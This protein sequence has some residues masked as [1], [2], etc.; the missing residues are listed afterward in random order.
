MNKVILENGRAN[1]LSVGGV[2]TVGGDEGGAIFNDRGI[3]T[4]NNSTIRNNEASDDG[5]AIYNSDGEVTINNSTINANQS[6]GTTTDGGVVENNGSNAKLI[7]NSSTLSGNTGDLGGAIRNRNGGIVEINNSTLTQNTSISGG[8]GIFNDNSGGAVTIK[9][10][11]IAGNI[12]G[13]TPDLVGIVTGDANNLIG[14]LTG[15]TGSIG[16]GTD[17]VDNRLIAQILNPILAANGLLDR[18]PFTHALVVG[19][20]AIDAGNSFFNTDQRGVIAIGNPDIGAYEKGMSFGFI[21]QSTSIF[22]GLSVEDDS[23]TAPIFADIDGDGLQDAIVGWGGETVKFFKNT[24]TSASPTLTEQVGVSNPFDGISVVDNQGFGDFGVSHPDLVD[25]DRDGDLDLFIGNAFGDIYFYENTDPTN[26]KTNPT[27]STIATR[28]TKSGDLFNISSVNEYATPTF[29]DID[30]DGDLDLF[31]GQ[32]DSIVYYQNQ[33]T[34]TN[35]SFTIQTG[36]IPL[37]SVSSISSST[38]AHRRLNVDFL[39]VNSDGDFDAFIGQGNGQIQYYENQGNSSNPIFVEQTGT[40]NPFNDYNITLENRIPARELPTKTF[41]DIDNDGDLEA[42]VG[43]RLQG[44]SNSDA[45]IKFF[46]FNSPPTSSETRLPVGENAAFDLMGLTNLRKDT[47]FNWRIDG[48][49]NPNNLLTG[50][51]RFSVAVIDSGLDK[52][53]PLLSPN[54]I[55]GYDFDRNT[56]NPLDIDGHGTHVSGTIGATDPNMGVAPGVGLIGLQTFYQ[57]GDEIFS[58]RKDQKEALDWIRNHYEKHNIVAVNM[59]LGNGDFYTSITDALPDERLEK[60]RDL[61][62]LGISVIISAGNAYDNNEYYNNNPR[63]E[64]V[65][66]P[67]IFGTLVIGSIGQTQV[68]RVTPFSQRLSSATN[69]LFA[70]GEWIVSIVSSDIIPELDKD[71]TPETKSGTSMAAPHV[72]GAV[73][74]LQEA[75]LE[76]GG[77]KLSTDRVV[78]FFRDNAAEIQDN[79]EFN[80]SITVEE[81]GEKIRKEFIVKPTNKTYKYLDLHKSIQALQTTFNSLGQDV[82]GTIEGA[83]LFTSVYLP[84]T[85]ENDQGQP[86]SYN[87]PFLGSI[88]IDGVSSNVGATDVDLYHIQLEDIGQQLNI[89]LL[90]H[91]T[92]PTD[93]FNAVVRLFD[94]EGNFLTSAE[95]PVDGSGSL[96]YNNLNDIN[97]NEPKELVV[98]ISGAG[99]DTYNPNI[100]NSSTAGSTGNYKLTFDLSVP[101][102]DGTEDTAPLAEL[103]ADGSTT[104]IQDAIGSDGN[105]AVNTLS[106]V[107]MQKIVI[108]DDG[109][110]LIDIDTAN[111]N[112]V[113]SFLRVFDAAGNPV[114]LNDR[115]V[116]ENNNA[117]AVATTPTG[118]SFEVVETPTNNSDSFLYF[119]A[120]KGQT[121]YIGISEESVNEDYNAEYL[122]QRPDAATGGEYTLNLNFYKNNPNSNPL[123]APS[124]ISD[125]DGSIGLAQGLTAT[126][127]PIANQRGIIGTDI[128]PFSKNPLEV[129]NNDVDFYK[130]NSPTTGLLSVSVDSLNNANISDPLDAVL[131]L[132]TENGTPIASTGNSNT[133]DADTGVSDR[134]PRLIYEIEANTDY[135]IAVTGEGT[136]NFDPELMGSGSP[137]DTGEYILNSEVLELEELSRLSDDKIGNEGIREI[138]IGDERFG[139]VGRD[140]DLIIGATDIDLYRFNATLSGQIQ[141]RTQTNGEFSADTY[142]RLFD[143]EGKEIAANDDENELTR[144]SFLAA[145]VLKGQ[146]YY[147]GVNGASSQPGAYNPITGEG[148]VAGVQGDYLLTLNGPQPRPLPPPLPQTEPEILSKKDNNLFAIAGTAGEKMT[149]RLSISQVNT[150]SVSEIGVIKVDDDRGSIDGKTS[151]TND[152]LL[153]AMERATVVASALPDSTFPRFNSDRLLEFDSGDRLLFYMVQNNTTDTVL[154]TLKQGMTPPNVFF[155]TGTNVLNA[156]T[157]SSDRFTLQWEDQFG[158][159][160]D[161]NDIEIVLE[162]AP[163]AVKALGTKWQGENEREIVDLREVGTQQAT[164]VLD[165]EALYSNTVGFYLAD[166][167]T[168]RIGDLQPGDRGYAKIALEER[169][170][171]QLERSGSFTNQLEGLLVPFIIAN[172]QVEQFLA[173]NPDNLATGNAIAYFP[174][175][176]ANPDGVDHIR[177]LG[178][179]TFG[180]EDLPNGGDLDYNDMVFQVTFA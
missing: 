78:K 74:I 9:N 169:R 20:P 130:V 54:Y 124:D 104:S 180:F 18:E 46:E 157:S 116:A 80:R 43:S 3:V 141:I 162:Y 19:S 13:N 8:G 125:P 68:K 95:L 144:G 88:G 7:I 96:T 76:L 114:T 179:N 155:A 148:I 70:P 99:N 120:A 38:A 10:S 61:E 1:T 12:G 105:T 160:L 47:S 45:G 33:G 63:Q 102:I 44:I 167:E 138:A 108:P 154:M 55:D 152:Y 26:N 143:A 59:S 86:T 11:I 132:L 113:K 94:K 106:D 34:S 67:G 41:V 112:F 15:S 87:F 29:V 178:D 145:N 36:T 103:E 52:D 85:L 166:D 14:N 149:F 64:G 156:S 176:A 39:D 75:S 25:I 89:N 134:D 97:P 83:K 168:G 51:K 101:D 23:Q 40:D 93:N 146:T 161:F 111:T 171:L 142:L 164:L 84:F 72:A 57:A 123:N 177:L 98:G 6:L 73:S 49:P 42:F 109:V 32:Y 110:V 122:A 175:M 118:N 56:P 128:D 170:V 136:E 62:K 28:S 121:Y 172:A 100:I 151:G 35:P 117:P 137:G 53:E 48:T 17:I 159:S 126:P 77:R 140:R 24:G 163:N 119:Q 174:Y 158:G 90:P 107:D 31:I 27:F 50:G 135:F 16:T 69:M 4:I 129:G 22:D 92:D 37:N 147:I 66:S 2:A 153:A 79:K 115:T 21:E 65:G 133:L 60:I 139:E 30:G 82:D 58:S 5:G 131:L 127:L 81:N 150:A 71:N 91:P 173:D 165:G